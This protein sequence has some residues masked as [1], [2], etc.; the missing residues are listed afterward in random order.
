MLSVKGK[1]QLFI[2]VQGELMKIYWSIIDTWEAQAKFR[3]KL[4]LI[5]LCTSIFK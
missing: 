1:G 2:W 5:P 4:Q 3:K